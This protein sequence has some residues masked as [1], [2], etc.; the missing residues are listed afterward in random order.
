MLMFRGL[1]WYWYTFKWQLFIT[2]K[3]KLKYISRILIRVVWIISSV[4]WSWLYGDTSN[5]RWVMHQH[6]VGF[7]F[8]SCMPRNWRLLLTLLLVR[9]DAR[10]PGLADKYVLFSMNDCYYA[11][12]RSIKVKKRTTDCTSPLHTHFYFSKLFRKLNFNFNVIVIF[13]CFMRYAILVTFQSWKNEPTQLR[14]R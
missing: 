5:R 10:R 9:V 11:H 8:G 3:K 12:W 4:I 1:I 2:G 14:L 13:E 7:W 6:P